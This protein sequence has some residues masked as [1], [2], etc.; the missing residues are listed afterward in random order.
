LGI[1]KNGFDKSK[2]E[3]FVNEKGIANKVLTKFLSFEVKQIKKNKKILFGCSC[4][5]AAI[6]K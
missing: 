6:K 3:H 4:L 5:I 1:I 2:K